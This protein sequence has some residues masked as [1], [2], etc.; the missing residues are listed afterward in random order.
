[1][2]PTISGKHPGLGACGLAH[3]DGSLGVM[4][5]HSGVG[6]VEERPGT[7]CQSMSYRELGNWGGNI[8]CGSACLGGLAEEEAELLQALSE[9][10]LAR[11]DVNWDIREGA[12]RKQ[13]DSLCD[14]VHYSPG[15]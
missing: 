11:H 8:P 3:H 15:R 6:A 7:G 2:C 10:V 9:D 4:L 5:L 1:M 14:A 13:W 12:S